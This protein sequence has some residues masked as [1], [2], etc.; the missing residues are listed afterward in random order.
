MHVCE[1]LY[2][3]RKNKRSFNLTIQPHN[4][5]VDYFFMEIKEKMRGLHFF[6]TK[7]SCG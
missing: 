6:L 4:L 7:D 1:M 3:M 5:S 2:A